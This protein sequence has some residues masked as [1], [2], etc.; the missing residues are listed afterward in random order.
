MN[1]LKRMISSVNLM[2][3]KYLFS[4]ILALLVFI[5]T[6]NLLQVSIALLE[7]GIIF[8]ISNNI[9]KKHI[10]LAIFFNNI[11]LL[12]YNIQML[13]LF[14]GA[15]FLTLVMV[16]NVSS[17]N[18]L[19]GNFTQYAIGFLALILF[20]FLPI[21]YV[22][23]PKFTTSGMLSTFLT[24]ELVLTMIFSSAFSPMYAYYQLAHQAKDYI[25]M[26]QQV[27][28]DKEDFY[29]E[30]IKHFINKPENLVEKPNVVLIFT[31]GLSQGIVND[32]RNIMPNV[33]EYQSKSLTFDNY[34][35][36]TF[37][38]FSG[39]VGQ[40]YSGYNQ[41]IGDKNTLI[42]MQSI[43][44]DQ[45]YYTSIVN[46]EPGNKL[47]TQYLSDMNFD[48]VLG[49]PNPNYKGSDKT[50]SDGEAYEFLYKTIEKQAKS[51]K[52]FFTSIYTYG[53]HMSL[54]SPDNQFKDGSNPMLNKFY[55]ADIHFANFMKKFEESQMYD[56]T[57]II[58][59][60]DH[61]TFMD[62]AYKETYPDIPRSNPDLDQIPLFIYHKDVTAKHIDVGGRNSLGLAPTILDYLNISAENYFLGTSLFAPKK[63]STILDTTF[64]DVVYFL[65][66]DN[67][68]IRN[69][70]EKT[71]QNVLQ[72]IQA[73]L[74]VKN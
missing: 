34:Y 51:D 26:K 54:D 31:E 69:F 71:S 68:E 12:L 13:V 45:G 19:M 2:F 40:L 6:R 39:I 9:A 61:G 72:T 5:P 59:T 24:A 62:A 35:N 52:P 49:E 7:I 60:T 15:N 21:K 10:K 65:S 22:Q 23:I 30:D 32:P 8:L 70:D 37:A 63:E 53:T 41:E 3:I 25:E 43:L 18:G 44:K 47:F 14:F 29:K 28:A 17:I 11:A 58:F 73:Y 50:M 1:F 16:L 48:D 57:I 55:D 42:S 64:Y 56:D 27:I 33:R 46:T 74:S 67:G 20:T 66:T 38:T 36:H 4:V